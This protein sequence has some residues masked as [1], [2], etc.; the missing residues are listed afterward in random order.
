MLTTGLQTQGTDGSIEFNGTVSGS[1]IFIGSLNAIF[2][3]GHDSTELN[4]VV[5]FNNSLLKINGGTVLNTGQKFQ[6]NGSN[7][8]L[9]LNGANAVN[10]ANIRVGGTNLMA[11]RLLHTCL[12]PSQCLSHCNRMNRRI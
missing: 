9:E 7:A 2:G 11:N 10:G 6:V 12:N 3:E 4:E 8:T 5:F 1:A